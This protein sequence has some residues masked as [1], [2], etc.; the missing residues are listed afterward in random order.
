LLNVLFL[1]KCLRVFLSSNG[2][3]VENQNDRLDICLRSSK[4][5]WEIFL[6]IRNVYCLSPSE[7]LLF[8]YNIT[9]I[10]ISNNNWL[11]NWIWSY[12][13]DCVVLLVDW[14]VTSWV[15]STVNDW[16][17][18]QILKSSLIVAMLNGLSD[19]LIHDH[20]NFEIKSNG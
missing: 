2:S 12:N 7:I 13:W 10:T 3:I 4:S 11:W 9:S 17:L 8:W 5:L 20:V 14:N 6:F 16:I 1:D 18:N 19:A 15:D